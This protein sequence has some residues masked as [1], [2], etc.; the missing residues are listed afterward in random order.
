[1]KPNSFAGVKKVFIFADRPQLRRRLTNL[2]NQQLDL[3]VCAE[4]GNV[5]EALKLVRFCRPHVALVDISASGSPCAELIRN[6]RAASLETPVVVLPANDKMISGERPLRSK[7]RVQAVKSEATKRVIQSIRFALDSKRC[8]INEVRNLLILPSTESEPYAPGFPVD[9]IS[10]REF[11]AFK[12]LGLGYSN[13]QVAQE[14]HISV[15]TMGSYCSRIKEKL[16]LSNNKALRHE[17]LLW[18]VRQ[19]SK[20]NAP[21]A[22]KA[23]FLLN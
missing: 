4:S 1:M 16:Q 19:N 17:A 23:R 5:A 10:N 22:P 20:K 9:L 21:A 8:L 2:I 12:L 3:V 11:E 18:Q 7:K 6:I 14:L 13:A 15:N